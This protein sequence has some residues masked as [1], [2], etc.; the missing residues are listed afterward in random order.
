MQ[1]YEVRI[2]RDALHD[3]E[4]IYNY[5]AEEL[6][7]PD[8]ALGQYNRIAEAINSLS[9]MPERRRI[10]ESEPERSRGLRKLR[11]DNYAVFYF[12]DEESVVVTNVLYGASDIES[13]LKG[14][15]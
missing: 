7:V 12:I 6:L 10:L 8:T 14:N 2:T 5:I 1:R 3:M 9:Q 13:R 15:Y 11:V 4:S